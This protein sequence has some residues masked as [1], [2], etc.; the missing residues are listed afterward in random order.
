MEDPSDP[1][2]GMGDLEPVPGDPY[3]L[4][5]KTFWPDGRGNPPRC[6]GCLIEMDLATYLDLGYV[7][8][9]CDADWNTFPL[10]STHG[11]STP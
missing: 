1:D 6:V 8:G 9:Q 4:Q 11:G 3:M 7:C 5:H 2:Y 10:K